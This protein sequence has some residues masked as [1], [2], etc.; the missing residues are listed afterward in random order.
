MSLLVYGKPYINQIELIRMIAISLPIDTILL[1]KEHPAMIGKRS[2][3]SYNKMLNIPR[4]HLVSPTLQS[5]DIIQNSTALAVITG[6]M[7]LEA[8]ILGK[9]V[10]TF[11]DCPYNILPDYMVQRIKDLRNL[12]Q[13]L[14]NFLRNYKYNQKAILSYIKAVEQTSVD[15]NLYSVL[16]NKKCLFK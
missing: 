1:V 8:A 9:P 16:L 10:I 3:K 2:I 14:S 11:G 5:R 7:A 6:S 13:T 15:I 12:P 4:V